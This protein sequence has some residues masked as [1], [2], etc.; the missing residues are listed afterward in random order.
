MGIGQ[1]QGN[2]TT[3]F[4]SHHFTSIKLALLFHPQKNTNIGFDICGSQTRVITPESSTFDTY[5]M[6]SRV[7]FPYFFGHLPGIF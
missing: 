5:A 1:N 4:L 2:Y 6:T 3:L 7:F